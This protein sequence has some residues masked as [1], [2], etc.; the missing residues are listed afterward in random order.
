MLFDFYVSVPPA[1]AGAGTAA[2]A[3]A[4]VAVAE[5]EKTSNQHVFRWSNA[6]SLYSAVS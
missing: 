2:A 6:C 1:A 4:V 3:A 5:A